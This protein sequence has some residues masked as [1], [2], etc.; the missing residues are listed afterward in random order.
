LAFRYGFA[1]RANIYRHANAVGLFKSA[2]PIE[3]RYHRS[4]VTDDPAR[5][6]PP[7]RIRRIAKSGTRCSH[8]SPRLALRPPGFRSPDRFENQTRRVIGG[9]DGDRITA[10]LVSRLRTDSFSRHAVFESQDLRS[11]QNDRT[12]Y[13]RLL[14]E[15]LCKNGSVPTLPLA[16]LGD[17]IGSRQTEARAALCSLHNVATS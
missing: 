15:H 8:R 6:R 13:V 3:S 2:G 9:S 17:Q 1:D 16:F 11:G 10:R 4:P 7:L 5:R 14:L 12:Y